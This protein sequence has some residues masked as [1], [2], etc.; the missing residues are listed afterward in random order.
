MSDPLLAGA[1]Y[2][3]LFLFLS[4]KW[5]Q[6]ALI[7]IFACAPFQ[8]DVSIGGPVRFS[9]AEVNLAL[10]AFVFV[11]RFK[12]SGR[13]IAFGP[14]AVPLLIYLGVC[15]IS[16]IGDFRGETT[17][18]SFLQMTIYLIVDV[19]V[20]TWLAPKTSHFRIVLIAML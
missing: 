16:S 3:A 20:F 6:F 4:F 17:I 1:L 18:V 10:A 7:A 2:A 19:L 8:N 11:M 9:L 14:M 13:Q 12:S 5:P 15:I